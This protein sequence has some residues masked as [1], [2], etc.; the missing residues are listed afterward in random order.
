MTTSHMLHG[1]AARLASGPGGDRAASA[2]PWP[3]IGSLC[4]GYGGLDMAVMDVLGGS[5]AWH[6]QY[7]PEDKHQYAAKILEH[8]WPG[9]PNY[10]DITAI[11]GGVVRDRAGRRADRRVPVPGPQLRR[12]W[13]RDQGRYP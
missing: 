13:C 6:C 8:R 3:R 5:M 12:P 1:P 4:T 2:G 11:R 9:V 7:D 10:G